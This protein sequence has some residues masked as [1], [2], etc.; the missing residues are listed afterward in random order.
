MSYQLD[1]FFCRAVGGYQAIVEAFSLRQAEASS[2][3]LSSKQNKQTENDPSLIL[4]Q[5]IPFN[6]NESCYQPN[7]AEV[8]RESLI[9]YR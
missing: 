7:C 2:T 4:T 6:P 9:A 3:S 1:H 5:H 8:A